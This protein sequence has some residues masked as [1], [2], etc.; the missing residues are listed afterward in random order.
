[1]R[2]EHHVPDHGQRHDHGVGLNTAYNIYAASEDPKLQ[3]VATYLKEHYIDQGKLGQP[4][5]E[6]FYKSSAAT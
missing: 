6:G 4:T 1:M 5:G 2:K 3:A